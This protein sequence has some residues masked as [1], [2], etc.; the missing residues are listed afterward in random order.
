MRNGDVRD[1]G[2][3]TD[4]GTGTY[5][6]VAGSQV[7]KNCEVGR[8]DKGSTPRDSC[9]SCAAGKHGGSTD[10]AASENLGCVL[11]DPGTYQPSTGQATCAL[12]ARGKSALGTI[13]IPALSCDDCVAGKISSVGAGVCDECPSGTYNDA[14][15][16]YV[17]KNCAANTYR[18]AVAGTLAIVSTDCMDCPANTYSPPGSTVPSELRRER[19]ANNGCDVNCY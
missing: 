9:S 8:Y 19:R 14:T 16:Q 3:C 4:C 18:V 7:C 13:A 11:C 6:D 12:C 2:V 10:A 1:N 5:T 17:C 15:I